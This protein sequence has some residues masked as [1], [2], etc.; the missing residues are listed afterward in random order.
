MQNTSFPMVNFSP[1][2]FYFV[3]WCML[4]NFRLE[5]SNTV[6]SALLGSLS[7]LVYSSMSLLH[8]EGMG[9]EKGWG[10]GHA[11]QEEPQAG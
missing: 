2:G 9:W 4:G 5:G 7:V 3:L 11:P 10:R 8:E 1:S 6:V